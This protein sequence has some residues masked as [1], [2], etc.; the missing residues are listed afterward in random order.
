MRALLLLICLSLFS[1]FAQAIA[2]IRFQKNSKLTNEAKEAIVDFVN[3][4]CIFKNWSEVETYVESK[5]NEEG[6]IE[7]AAF[8]HLKIIKGSSNVSKPA[9]FLQIYTEDFSGNN[10]GIV[11]VKVFDSYPEDICK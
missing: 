9:E 2:Y 10:P 3:K 8:T 7:T 1:N 6:E 11:S 4:K 5:Q